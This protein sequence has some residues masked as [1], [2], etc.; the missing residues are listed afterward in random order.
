MLA[1]PAAAP[2]FLAQVVQVTRAD[3]RY[4]WHRGCPVGPARPRLIRL[5]YWGF[6][7]RP[8]VG[9]VVVTVAV[10]EEVSK[11][12]EQLYNARFP[13]R[14]MHPIHPASALPL[15]PTAPGH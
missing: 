14:P 2:S 1:T 8:H 4:S 9:A 10:V 6:D 3:V 5:G 7:G 11:A 12:F 15:R 13:I